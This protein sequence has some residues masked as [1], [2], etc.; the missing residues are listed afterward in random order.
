MAILNSYFYKGQDL[1][2]DGDVENDILEIV[3]QETDYLDVL[4][5]DNRWP[6]L[7]H[8]SPERRNL[9]EWYP[10]KRNAALLEIGAGCGAMTGLFCEKAQRVVA[11]ELS[12]RRAEIILNRYESIENLE[13]AA[14]N[15]MDMN[16]DAQFDYVTLI[17]VL[18][19]VR[20]F[21]DSK[22]PYKDYFNKLDSLLIK[23][24]TLI[25]A[26]ENKFGLKYFSGAGED[27]TGNLFENIE[28]Y[29]TNKTH[30]TFGKSE[31]IQLFN[32]YGFTDLEFYYP[33]PD[34]KLP[35]EIYSDER[36]PD[37]INVLSQA[38]NFDRERFLLFNE[39]LAY[40]NII[41]NNHFDFFANS[42][43]IF[44]RKN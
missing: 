32:T 2:S 19:Y 16:F 15:I 20:G 43:L 3:R 10:F 41:K 13:I 1:Y 22:T 21:V 40:L 17:G 7:Y 6:V 25:V 28:G 33:H 29:V 37:I 39:K 35:G 14:G 44:G 24:G 18:E 36:L 5:N 26:I 12:M 4:F 8:L 30:E 27:H 23:G 34:Y 42:F 31:I 38:P 9:L 11:V